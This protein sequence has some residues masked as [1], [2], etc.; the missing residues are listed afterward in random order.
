[1][2]IPD[3]EITTSIDTSA[4][5]DRKRAALKAHA[6]QLADTVWVQVGETEFAELFGQETFMRVRDRTGADLPET[7][8][9]AG[10]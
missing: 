6:S 7:D 3:A 10:V 8:L 1:M 9:F 2:G 4:V 5:L